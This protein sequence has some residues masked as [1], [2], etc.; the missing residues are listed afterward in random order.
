MKTN[1]V[2]VVYGSETN[3]TKI[4]M[5]E[6]VDQWKKSAK[7]EFS[8]VEMLEGDEAAEKFSDIT[9]KNYDFLLVATSSYGEGEAPSGFGK[10]LYQLQEAAKIGSESSLS[11]PQHAVLGFGS[12]SYET[13]Q[14]CPRLCDKYLG[15]AGSRRFLK[16][17]EFDEMEDENS[18]KIETWTNDVYKTATKGGAKA[19]K[20]D[21]VCSW[22]EPE[23][24]ILPKI[25]GEDGDEAGNGVPEMSSSKV[26]VLSALVAAGAAYYYYAYHMNDAE[27]VA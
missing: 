26:M 6:I 24:E 21:H 5:T 18:D 8:V 2:L 27:P 14:N 20:L 4:H 3:Q 22:E 7:S 15:E 25:M 19:A 12:T 13:Y 23:S 9:S 11:G 16:R 1:R 17:V 10:F